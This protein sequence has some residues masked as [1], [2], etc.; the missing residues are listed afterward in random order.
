MISKKAGIQDIPGSLSF[1][2]SRQNI[3]LLRGKGD[4][5]VH[6]WFLVGLGVR[7]NLLCNSAIESMIA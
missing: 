4:F 6:L 1:P 2:G 5:V 3:L 7:A